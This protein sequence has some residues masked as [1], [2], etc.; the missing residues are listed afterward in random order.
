M[1]NGLN[2][3][4]QDMYLGLL[5]AENYPEQEPAYKNA[6]WFHLFWLL[7]PILGFLIFILI[8]ENKES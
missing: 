4:A 8:I 7:V 6:R 5:C 2:K 3:Y 1:V